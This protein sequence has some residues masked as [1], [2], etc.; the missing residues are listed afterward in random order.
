[1]K[2]REFLRTSLTVSTLAGLSSASL[3]ASAAQT[4]GKSQEY[5]ELRAYR[6]RSGASH[7][8]LDAYLEKAAIPAW[9]RLSLKPVGVFVQQDRQDTPGKSEVRDVSVVYVLIPYPSLEVFAT[10]DNRV[11]ADPEYQ[12]AGAAYL[13]VAKGNAAFER[14]D[15]WLMRAFAGIPRIEQPAYSLEK[16]PR[17]FEMRTYES[18]SE[19]K[20]LKKVEM[21]N[22]GEIEAMREAGLGPVFFGQSLIGPSLPHLIYML[23]AESQELHKEHWAAFQKHP[24]W[25]KLKNDPQYADTVSRIRNQFLVPAA[26]SQI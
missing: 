24:T 1:M 3:A 25:N 15:G 14:I 18:Y 21:F 19:V 23:S 4:A 7:D 16:K 2:R 5:Y 8:L 26:Y 13:E 22:V 20:A 6:I 12:K 17:M 11:N 9:N 10:A